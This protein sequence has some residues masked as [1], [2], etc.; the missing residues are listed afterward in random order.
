MDTN[1]AQK[2]PDIYADKTLN[3]KIKK[4]INST[5]W[6]TYYTAVRS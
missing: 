6:S 1:H 3:A 5:V 4:E 2:N